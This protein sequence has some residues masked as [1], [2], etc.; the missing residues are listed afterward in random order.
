[1]N[2]FT[3]RLPLLGFR[4]VDY[5]AGHNTD[6]SVLSGVINGIKAEMDGIIDEYRRLWPDVNTIMTGGD[7]KYFEKLL[8]ND[9]FAFPNLVVTGLKL[10]LDFNL[11]K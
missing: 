10:I 2:T 3:G 11:E 1:L 4:P 9:I 8:K 5:L 6:E 7:A